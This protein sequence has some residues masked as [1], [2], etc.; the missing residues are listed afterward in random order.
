VEPATALM[1]AVFRCMFRLT[2]VEVRIAPGA[3]PLVAM[4]VSYHDR[5]SEGMLAAMLDHTVPAVTV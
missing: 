3:M 1:T 5:R 4:Y 2:A